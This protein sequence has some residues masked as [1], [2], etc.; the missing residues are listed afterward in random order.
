MPKI[1]LNPYRNNL[2]IEGLVLR[3]D[4]LLDQ[5]VK[6]TSDVAFNSIYVD[7]LIATGNVRFTGNVTEVN[8]EHV[9]FKD[10]IIDI[11]VANTDPLLTGGVRINRGQ[12]LTPFDILY[13]E[14]DQV[15]RTGFSDNLQI[16]AN[17]G[18]NLQHGY[19]SVWNNTNNRFDTTNTF[20]VPFIFTNTVKMASDLV[21]GLTAG[22]PVITSNT[23]GDF[24]LESSGNITLG[25]TGYS[26]KS[27]LIPFGRSLNF[28]SSF[29]KEDSFGNIVLSSGKLILDTTEKI[30][31][32]GTGVGDAKIYSSSDGNDLYVSG[33]ALNL[34]AVGQINVTGVSINHG[35]IGKLACLSGAVYEIS[36]Q[37]DISLKPTQNG[38][39]IIPKLSLNNLVNFTSNQMGQLTIDS[40]ANMIF[41]PQNFLLMNPDKKICF[42]T[43]NLYIGNSSDTNPNLLIKSNQKIILDAAQLVYIPAGVSLK[44]ATGTY[45]NESLDSTSNFVSENGDITFTTKTGGAVRI[46]SNV[47]IYFGSSETV[48]GNN[49]TLSITA[50]NLVSFSSANGL[51]VAQNIPFQF[52]DSRIYQNLTGSFVVDSNHEIRLNASEKVVLSKTVNVGTTV[53]YQDVDNNLALT[54]GTQGTFVKI[55]QPLL[56]ESTLIASNDKTASLSTS[57]GAYIDKNLIVSGNVLL[58]S[59]AFISNTVVVSDTVLPVKITNSSQTD[60]TSMSLMS[61]WDSNSSYTIGRGMSTLA[62]GRSMF[63]TVPLYSVY[64][65]GK[66]PSFVFGSSAYDVYAE[67]DSIGMTLN[68]KLNLTSTA[69]DAFIVSGKGQFGSLDATRFSASN[70]EFSATSGQVSI[71]SKLSVENEVTVKDSNGNVFFK[72]NNTDILANKNST[73]SENVVIDKNLTLNGTFYAKSAVFTENVDLSNKKIMNLTLPVSDNDAASKGYVDSVSRGLTIK[74]A[75]VAA[76]TGNIDLTSA[77]SQLDNVTLYS[78][79][80]ILVKNQ[81]DSKENGVYIIGSGNVPTR[82]NDMPVG[83][84]VAGNSLFVSSGSLNGSTGF[85]IVG[86][87]IIVGTNNINWTPFSGA[88]TINAG[89]GILK[90]GNVFSANVDNVSIKTSSSDKLQV[91]PTFFTTGLT[92]SDTSVSTSQNQSH[93]TSVGV[94]TSGTWNASVVSPQYGGTGLTNIT[95]G[96]I[97]VGNGNNALSNSGDLYW[98]NLGK[99]LGVGTNTPQANLHVV[100]NGPDA[101]L[102]TWLNIQDKNTLTTQN[103]GILVS[104]QSY[105]AKV[106]LLNSGTLYI[107]QENTNTASKIVFSTQKT[108]RFIIDSNGNCV[109]GNVSVVAGNLLTVAGSISA[110]GINST[111]AIIINDSSINNDSLLPG[112][113]LVTSQNLRLTGTL[114]VTSDASIGNLKFITSVSGENTI[115]SVNKSNNTTLPLKLKTSTNSVSAT[116][117]SSGFLVPNILQIGGVETDQTT[118]FVFQLINDSLE[119]TPNIANNSVIFNGKV[120]SSSSIQYFDK[121]VSTSVVKQYVEAGVFNTTAQ[122]FNNIAMNY[123]VGGGTS[124]IISQFV[125]KNKTGYVKYD[126]TNT[127]ETSGG[128]FSVS[129]TVTT[130]F[131]NQVKLSES[132]RFTASNSLTAG[133]SNAGWYYFGELGIGR[134]TIT[135]SL[136]FRI[137]ID[138]DGLSS[139]TYSLTIFDKNVCS[140]V[141]YR[142]S[143]G[144]YHLFLNV[145]SNPVYVNVVESPNVF[146]VTSYE[147]SSTSPNGSSSGYTNLWVKDFDLISSQSNASLEFGSLN[148]LGETHLKNPFFT[149]ATNISG[150]INIS[151]SPVIKGTLFS[152]LNPNTDSLAVALRTDSS[153]NTVQVYGQDSTAP[154]IKINKDTVSASIL[155]NSVNDANYPNALT[156]SHKE[157][158]SFSKIILATRD[159]SR[160]VIDDIGNVVFTS[161]TDYVDDT[162]ASIVVNGGSVFKKQAKFLQPVYIKDLRLTNTNNYSEIKLDTDSNVSVENARISNLANPVNPKDAVTK[163]YVENLLQG[164]SP[165]ESVIVA[166]TGQNVDLTTPL[167]VLDGVLLYDNQ[168]ILLKDQANP[169]ENGIYINHNSDL[170]TRSNDMQTGSSAASIFVFVGQGTMN[171]NSGWVCSAIKNQDTVGVNALLFTQFSGAGQFNAGP[172]LSKIGN[173][174]Q[175]TVDN[176]SLEVVSNTIRV[177][178]TLAGTGL[179][180]GSGNSLSV[181]SIAHLNTLGTIQ[182]GT[183]NASVIG[184]A[185]GGTGRSSFAVG[186]IPFSNGASLSQGLLYYDD[187]NARLG[188][189]TTT[190]TAGLTL[191]DRDIQL[192]QI[193]STPLYTILTSTVT[194]YSYAIRNDYEN[195]IISGGTGTN[196]LSLTDFVTLDKTGSLT[197]ASGFSSN[198]TNIGSQLRI[199]SDK[200]EKTVNG[201]FGL[202]LF[203]KDNSGTYINLYGGLGIS[204]N[205]ANSEFLRVGFY[206]GSY[207]LAT[208]STG[209]GSTRNLSL[210]TGSNTN[211]IML[212]STGKT[213][214]NGEIIVNETTNATSTTSGGALTVYGGAG[215]S[216]T[217]YAN[218]LN[219]TSTSSS[220]ALFAGGVVLSKITVSGSQN[221]SVFSNSANKLNI[222]GNSTLQDAVV[223]MY[224]KDANN[225]NNVFMNLYGR[226]DSTFTNSEYLQV[227]FD[228]ITT[229]YVVKTVAIG[230][231]TQ[232][233]L[234][235]SATVGSDQLV[236]NTDGSSVFAG[237]LQVKG[238]FSLVSTQDATSA[239][240]GGSLSLAG[241]LSVAKSVISGTKI[242]S[243]QVII[244]NYIE[245]SS[246]GSLDKV[247]LSY[248]STGNLNI[249]N[250][251]N[252]LMNIHTGNSEGPL[253]AN[254]EKIQI[255][256]QDSS[257]HVIQSTASGTGNVRDLVIKTF[258]NS[259]QLRLYANDGSSVFS[260]TLSIIS[261]TDATGNAT[262]SLKVSGGAS[263]TKSLYVGK[264][265]SVGNGTTGQIIK[266]NGSSQWEVKSIDTSLMIISSLNTN[267]VL[268]VTDTVGSQV[269][270]VDTAN[271]TVSVTGSQ[272]ILFSGA[273]AL[274][275]KNG[276]G[277]DLFVFDTTNHN[278]DISGGKIVNVANPQIGGDAANKAYVDNLIKGLNLKVAVD[279]ASTGNVNITSSITTIDSVQLTAG[280]RILLKNQTNSV[281]NGIYVVNV[282]NFLTRADDFAVGSRAAGAFTFIQKGA[283]FAEQ[284]YVCIA[285]YPSDIVGTN[286]LAFTQFNGNIIS[287]GQGLYKDG[288]NIMNIGLDTA[289]GLSF[290]GNKLR[291]DPSFAGSGLSINNGILSLLPISAVGTILAGSWQASVINVPYGG[292]GNTVY[293]QYGIV[294]S[295]GAK[296]VEDVSHFMWDSSK[297][298]L[299]INGTPDPNNANDGL[300]VV[301]KDIT[302]QGN[303]SGLLFADSN[304]NYNWRIRRLAAEKSSTVQNIP[305]SLWSNISFSKNGNIGILT[306]EINDPI[307][308]S[309]DNGYTWTVILNDGNQHVWAEPVLSSTGKYILIPESQGFVYKSSDYGS[310]FTQTLTSLAR[311]WEWSAI[312]ENGQYMLVSSNGDGV[313]RS[314]NFGSTWTSLTE[315]PTDQ[316]DISFVHICKN[317]TRQFAGYY[318]GGLYKSDNYGVSFSVDTQVSTQNWY[319]IV[320]STNSNIL[321]LFANPGTL[322][323]SSDLGSTWSEKL[324]S[325]Q[326]NWI[327][328]SVNSDGSL[329][330]A[331]AE[332]GLIYVSNNYGSSFTSVMDSVPRLWTFVIVTDDG[333]GIIAGGTNIPVYI[334]TDAGT[335]FSNLTS[336]NMNITSAVITSTENVYYAETGAQVNRYE[337]TDSTNLIISSG[338]S[339]SKSSLTDFVVINDKKQ[340]GINFSSTTEKNI[341]ATLDVNGNVHIKDTLALDIPLTTQSGGTGSSSLSYGL[342]VAN[343]SSPYATTGV[344][345]DGGVAIGKSDG[346]IHVESGAVLRDHLGVKINRD[347]QAWAENLDKISGLFPTNGYYITG[348]GQEFRMTSPVNVGANLGLGDLAYISTINDT[349]WSGQ[350]LS[351]LHGG[352][353]AA[354]LTSNNIPFYNGTKL[355]TSLLYNDTTLNGVAIGKTTTISGSGLLVYGKD[356]SIQ[357]G[358]DTVSTSFLFNNVNNMASWRIRRDDD[359][360]GTGKSNF[361]ISGGVPS[362]DKTA[363]TDNM[364]IDSTGKVVFYS[365]FDSTSSATGAVIITGGTS[366]QKGLTVAAQALFKSTVEATSSLSGAVILSGGLAVAKSVKIGNLLSVTGSVDIASTQEAT[367]AT[368]ASM[369]LSGGLGVSGK[370]YTS[371]SIILDTFATIG[372]KASGLTVSSNST[373]WTS[374][375][376]ISDNNRQVSLVSNTLNA[377]VVFNMR[378][379]QSVNGWDIIVEGNG[380][381]RM[382]W[383]SYSIAETASKA[384]MFLDS[385]TGTLTIT[386][387]NDATSGNSSSLHI[388]GGIYAEKRIISLDKVQVENELKITNTGNSDFNSMSL[389]TDVGSGGIV[390]VNNST[391]VSDGGANAMTIRNDSGD[392][393][394]QSSGGK[395]ILL[396]ATTG[397]ATL[398]SSLTV[399][400]TANA[401]STT[402]G[403]SLTVNGGLAVQK[404][405]FIGGN[406]TLTGTLNVSNSVTSPT[407]T[408]ASGDFVNI[409]T[410]TVKSAKLTVTN[411]QNSLVALF[412]V[413]P[414]ADSLNTQFTFSL[415]NKTTNLGERLD[416]ACQA[417]GFVDNVNLV[418]LENILAT[419]VT[420]A[421]KAVVKFQSVDNTIHYVQVTVVYDST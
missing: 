183:W 324:S 41:N 301:S 118:G 3:H 247:N 339:T 406:V 160:V 193:S 361:V 421:L 364:S 291:V 33:N 285:D 121:S 206:N 98:D 159:I 307:Y 309:N 208:S 122:T 9:L 404:D 94:L 237:S 134:T 132:L 115:L 402:S 231:T 35:G 111:G 342:I 103:S 322:F 32:G 17:R 385:V 368:S 348:N 244:S 217:V 389:Q 85:V 306:A 340:L 157:N 200:I 399:S 31:W 39:V 36:S 156:V 420:S 286:A 221:Y 170:L 77:L 408:T 270:S 258:N 182:N 164:L 329:I 333:L 204:S 50:L 141:I 52:G 213:S 346:K 124:N 100:N 317:G 20:T 116:C 418:V 112:G 25:S 149:G 102:G 371:N 319:D 297:K 419:G 261:T 239:V 356:V 238:A 21:L 220:S 326:K 188:I 335:T 71:T 351:V 254:Q 249:Y 289:S 46:G 293:S 97:L 90:T 152:W 252:N 226:T 44:L 214:F 202:N 6:T 28:G 299:G 92:A 383:Q 74:T 253:S 99:N 416:I 88:S 127:S 117:F 139:Y 266:L 219:I 59:S 387:T 1:L 106:S 37:G 142:S 257:S 273:K 294:Y 321:V 298:A 278:L 101:T 313:Y 93:V 12:G 268:S 372:K 151:G 60:G 10:S 5:P 369:T 393:R 362:T 153:G 392:V 73:F 167:T 320:E 172:G 355:A 104:N 382:I 180:G 67:I 407:L 304:A 87:P 212:F 327:S 290:N 274:S 370:V 263:V 2:S 196:K 347:V 131:K 367:S 363:L 400:S 30:V 48:T 396:T 203:S 352:T 165:K 72:V 283:T 287:A 70:N 179:S 190:P 305:D 63:F 282:S 225:A 403:G 390:F 318:G 353:G 125:N 201:V 401:T 243:P 300:T 328:V 229:S 232:K 11:N 75:V 267:S 394:L 296:L 81:T 337:Y 169:V 15:L 130:L 175:V 334:S 155:L 255:G 230:T 397:A 379:L 69:D 197:V 272:E 57:G 163:Q 86:T 113:L 359:G 331:V 110:T 279:A 330:A 414:T 123:T 246:A 91:K 366:I 248:T 168:R 215:F 264:T 76:T 61:T 241:G 316:V 138:Y 386:S 311:V 234:T 114:D 344:L 108:S 154:G 126:P 260:G 302:L 66:R 235:L 199:S 284:G 4:E 195:F 380:N 176:V 269:F 80:R 23:L 62:Q 358:D 338:K 323:V 84:N 143:T 150:S 256:Y 119:I 388:A 38:K 205:N 377:S 280:S 191:N 158:D 233:S 45:I 223:E 384:W 415:P 218:S 95:S 18:P 133:F 376:I 350:V 19:L 276:S 242:I 51:Y 171:N 42:G 22:S 177:K 345:P 8:A 314:G 308:L 312:S 120:K 16:V 349:L 56:A 224:S 381:N 186:R 310:T 49:G 251:G 105:S 82:S 26:G 140:L 240:S 405:V 184:M 14:T 373:T 147:G 129:E 96:N 187:T 398:S 79:D 135:A 265:L 275:I 336:R 209:N 83:A 185:Y 178:S 391:R 395:G 40:P 198:F 343:G 24:F 262:G 378:N 236:L 332:N 89:P 107:G 65:I 341:S 174:I 210:Q 55:I 354:T 137:R 250:N 148:V 412:K 53:I 288:N 277:T 207:T 413:T 245:M 228:K 411:N 374:G 7:E 58:K 409:T 325:T 192:V 109:V 34:G 68:G 303:S 271:K 146:S 410:L 292:T 47:P 360:S 181:S 222:S 27:I 295:D 145:I 29:L 194:N 375:D 64:G 166:S 43:S 136:S 162:I 216:G 365:T 13:S 281:E 161:T 259:N 315:L 173:T 144:V 227:G 128:Q 54:S 189:N 211:Q 357:N 78:Q 417:S